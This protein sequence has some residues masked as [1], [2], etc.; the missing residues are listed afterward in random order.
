MVKNHLPN[1]LSDLGEVA[2]I[3]IEYLD[4]WGNKIV[5]EVS[6][7]KTASLK[8][9]GKDAKPGGEK[10]NTDIIKFFSTTDNS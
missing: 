2:G 5:Y 8:S 6:N 1:Q 3:S 4:E 7:D 9:F 10:E